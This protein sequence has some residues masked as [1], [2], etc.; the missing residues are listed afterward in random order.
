MFCSCWV[1]EQKPDEIIVISKSSLTFRFSSLLASRASSRRRHWPTWL[2]YFVH[3]F[4]R[5]CFSQQGLIF[6]FIFLYKTT[7]LNKVQYPKNVKKSSKPENLV[8][9]LSNLWFYNRPLKWN[10]TIKKLLGNSILFFKGN[11]QFSEN[12]ILSEKCRLSEKRGLSEKYN[13]KLDS[14]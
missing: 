3:S 6:S 2:G 9:K 4:W 12:K 1:N 8:E 7:F 5:H 11:R 13:S 10:S 14:P